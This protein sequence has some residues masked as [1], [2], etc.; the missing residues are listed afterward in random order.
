MAS[1]V[2]PD[3]ITEIICYLP[4]KSVG[5]FR[6]V[7]KQWN[8]L[9]SSPHFIKTHQI[10]RNLNH[11]ISIIRVDYSLY[12]FPLDVNFNEETVPTKVDVNS[13]YVKS[14]ILHGSCNGL[15][16]VLSL[17]S[18]KK[19]AALVLLNPT[20]RE[21]IEISEPDYSYKETD[22]IKDRLIMTGFG[23]DS[24]TDDYKITFNY[25]ISFGCM[26]VH[27]Y[28]FRSG[29]WKQV[30]SCYNYFFG[31][32]LRGVFVDGFIHC[33]AKRSS[34][35]LRVILG[36]SLADEKFSE[37][38]SPDDVDIADLDGCQLVDLD[39]KLGIFLKSVGEVWLMNEYGVKESWTNILLEGLCKT[40]N[41]LSVGNALLNE[42]RSIL[43]QPMIYKTGKFLVVTN[44]VAQMSIYDIE[45]RR[46]SKNIKINIRKMMTFQGS[47]VESLVSPKLIRN[48]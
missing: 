19:N 2:P 18:Q 29:T 21:F 39:G 42:Y 27:V 26:Y 28:S 14:T 20:T 34:D 38:P 35:G 36:F 6:C 40:V 10:K 5:R 8:T 7:S 47:Y 3:I 37:V 31:Y 12:S 22:I 1:E 45:E 43:L 17:D 46:F 33:F 30:D 24:L 41:D 44:S 11:I 23:Y 4:A 9:L 25:L 13:R 15:V 48:N 16:L 32:M